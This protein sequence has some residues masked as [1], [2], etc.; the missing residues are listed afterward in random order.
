MAGPDSQVMDVARRQGAGRKR[1]ENQTQLDESDRQFVTALARGLDVLA[2]FRSG[3]DPLGNAELAQRTGLPKPTIS[4]ITL[5]LMQRGYLTYNARLNGYELGAAAVSLGHVA[6]ANLDV[7]RLARPYMSSFAKR[8][9]F[10]VGLGVRERLNMV[11]LE[12]CEGEGV[13]RLR[14]PVGSRVPIAMSAMGRA[15][16]AALP[17]EERDALLEQIRK[18]VGTQWPVLSK[19]IDKAIRS[20][21]ERGYCVSIG[22]WRDDI[23]GVGAPI[24]GAE[25]QAIYALNVGGPAYLLTPKLITEK[26]GQDLAQTAKTISTLFGRSGRAT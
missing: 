10:N 8:T 17:E 15:Y 3:D 26:V 9:D 20:V 12:T 22:E 16:L 23:N 6:L 25:G 13:V 24:V 19:A 11:Y 18:R 1:S 14:L 5:T 2:A 4:R 7:P 21:A